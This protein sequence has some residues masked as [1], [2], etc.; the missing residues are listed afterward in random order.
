[1]FQITNNLK[2]IVK[3]KCIT[4]EPEVFYNNKTKAFVSAKL[5]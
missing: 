4:V 1:M 5:K 2:C 3:N